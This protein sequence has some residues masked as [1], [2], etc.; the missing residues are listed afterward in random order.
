MNK[1]EKPVFFP[2]VLFGTLGTLLFSLVY[3]KLISNHTE[4]NRI[5]RQLSNDVFVTEQISTLDLRDIA[6]KYN[7]V[8][9]LR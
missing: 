7:A 9:D 2:A 6:G 3:F 8:V 5:Y 1:R 4:N